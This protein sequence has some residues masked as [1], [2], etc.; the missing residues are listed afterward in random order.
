MPATV[1]RL[2]VTVRKYAQATARDHVTGVPRAV[3]FRR[4]AP[5]DGEP[6]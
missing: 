3:D 6:V 5:R 4:G 2:S 1:R